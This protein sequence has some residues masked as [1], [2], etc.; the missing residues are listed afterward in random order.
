EIGRSLEIR[1]RGQREVVRV[2]LDAEQQRGGDSRVRD[3]VAGKRRQLCQ[4][5]RVNRAGRAHVRPNVGKLRGQLGGLAVVIDHGEKLELLGQIDAALAGAGID[6]REKVVFLQLARV[7][8]LPHVE[9]EQLDQGS[10]FR[11]RNREY[12]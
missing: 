11:P 10:I 6:E 4:I 2:G 8:D 12:V 5:H 3:R 1:R 7:G 9:V